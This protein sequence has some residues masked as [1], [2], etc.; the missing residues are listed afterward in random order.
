MSK[1]KGLATT[2]KHAQDWSAEEQLLT[3]QESHA[4][5]GEPLN[6]WCREHGLFAHHP[7]G[8]RTAFCAAGK[9]API[10]PTIRPMKGK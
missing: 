6:A 9:A 2:E 3:L 8:W 1:N 4:L 7:S 10:P 5:T